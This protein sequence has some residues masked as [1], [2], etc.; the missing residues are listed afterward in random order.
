MNSVVFFLFFWKAMVS[1]MWGKV[2]SQWLKDNAVF[3]H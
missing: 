3:L 1:R 2:K